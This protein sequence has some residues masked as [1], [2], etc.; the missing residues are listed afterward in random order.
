MV[1]EFLLH[2]FWREEQTFRQK[3]ASVIFLNSDNR[4]YTKIKIEKNRYAALLDSGAS[5]SCKGGRAASEIATQSKMRKC[6]GTIRTAKD[7]QWN[8]TGRIRKELTKKMYI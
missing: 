4:L 1:L 8:V 7:A 5:I 6:S 2:L 3:L